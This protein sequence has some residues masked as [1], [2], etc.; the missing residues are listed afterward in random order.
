MFNYAQINEEGYC[1][2]ISSLSGEVGSE[3]LVLIEG[4]NA[5]YINRRY[6]RSTQ[7]WTDEYLVS[8]L[9]NEIPYGKD[10]SYNLDTIQQLHNKLDLIME[11]LGIS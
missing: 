5:D 1:M 3:K 7:K 9:G 4:F 10:N 11:H 2:A 8:K 6:D